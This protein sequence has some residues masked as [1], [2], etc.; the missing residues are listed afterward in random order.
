MLTEVVVGR[1]RMSVPLSKSFGA[2]AEGVDGMKGNNS[3]IFRTESSTA[4]LNEVKNLGTYSMALGS[5]D[6]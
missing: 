1:K 5:H 6:N 4:R 3:V 2:L